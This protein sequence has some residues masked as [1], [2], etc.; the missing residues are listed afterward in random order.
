VWREYRRC[1]RPSRRIGGK[2]SEIGGAGLSSGTVP[3]KT[4]R[5]TALVLSG[6]RAAFALQFLMVLAIATSRKVAA[7]R[8]CTVI[9]RGKPTRAFNSSN[10]CQNLIKKPITAT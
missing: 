10:R 1:F 4:L 2:G 8:C 7:Q 6:W 9:G 5:E 3:S